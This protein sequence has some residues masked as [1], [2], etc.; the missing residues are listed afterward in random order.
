[1]PPRDPPADAPY[2]GVEHSEATGWV[3]FVLLGALMLVLLGALH[4]GIGLVALLHPEVLA[5]GRADRLV[6]VGLTALAWFHLVIGSVAVAVGVGLVRGHRWARI[7]AV[8][9]AG[10][11][12]LVNFAFVDVHPVW[13]VTA[14]A[15]IAIVIY[16]VAAH[17]AEVT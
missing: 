4:V 17:G 1:M 2:A 8:V 15:M 6:S 5:G 9:L 10:A 14:L 7:T 11:A 12:A 3:G 13:S 16:A